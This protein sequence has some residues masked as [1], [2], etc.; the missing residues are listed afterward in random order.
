M[1]VKKYDIV[2][3]DLD[4]V[5]GSEQSGIRPCLVIQNN[6]ANWRSSTTVVCSFT[7]VIK[8]YPNMVITE[9]SVG[10]GLDCKSRL[11]ILQIR[12][13]DRSRIVKKIGELDHRYRVEFKLKF[14]DSFDLED[15]F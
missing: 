7:S 2:I 12:T 1:Q 3:V 6:E 8:S 5:K 13:V 9:P 10:N 4:P 11:D 14:I 15:L